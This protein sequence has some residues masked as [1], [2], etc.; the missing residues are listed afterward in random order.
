MKYKEIN[1]ET[2][3]LSPAVFNSWSELFEK[4]V[5]L[6]KSNY[7]KVL[8]KYLKEEYKINKGRV[9]PIRSTDIFRA[10]YETNYSDVKVV[11]IG[12]EP[13]RNSKA[14]GVAFACKNV[15]SVSK[16]MTELLLTV[17]NGEQFKKD[18]GVDDFDL[19]LK[20]LCSQ[21]VLFLNTSLTSSF[22]SRHSYNKE[23]KEKLLT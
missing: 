1:I 20:G 16:S 5:P 3:G 9:F 13:Y 17:R 19:T 6:L 10:F 2:V 11:V 14:N 23:W 18:E 8:S 22:Y 4:R 21:G 7:L 12:S 15:L